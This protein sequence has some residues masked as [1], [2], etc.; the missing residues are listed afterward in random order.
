MLHVNNLNF[1][2]YT[3]AFLF[4]HTIEDNFGKQKQH[5]MKGLSISNEKNDFGFERECISF[6]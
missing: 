6:K 5:K 1:H 4:L 2:E 3:F